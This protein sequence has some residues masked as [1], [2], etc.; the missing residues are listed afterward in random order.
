MGGSMIDRNGGANEY[1]LKEQVLKR[2]KFPS[3]LMKLMVF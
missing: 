1:V 2:I 3:L